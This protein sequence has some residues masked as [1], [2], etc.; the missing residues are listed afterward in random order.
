[1]QYR[2]FLQSEEGGSGRFDN[3]PIHVIGFYDDRTAAF[4]RPIQRIASGRLEWMGDERRH[5][6]RFLVRNSK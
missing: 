4:T 5:P 1:M 6:A 2:H 3:A